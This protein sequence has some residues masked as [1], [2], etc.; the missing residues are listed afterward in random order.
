MPD[1]PTMNNPVT[2]D[3][4]GGDPVRVLIVDDRPE[5][6]VALEA[7][8]DDLNV[9]LVKARSG[10]EALG[11]AV[12][13][14]FA[15]ILLDVE[16]PGIDGFETAKLIRQRGRSKHT[17]ILFVTASMTTESDVARG[18]RIGAVD[19]VLKPFVPEVVRSKVI[20]FVD[21]FKL[22]RD[23]ERLNR[24]LEQKVAARTLELQNAVDALRS[25]VE[26]RK[27]IQHAL[28]ESEERY[29]QLAENVDHVFWI[30]SID[31]AQTVY[32]SPAYE[33]VWGRSC[34]SLYADPA[35]WLEAVE[36]EDKA[37]TLAALAAMPVGQAFRAEYRIRRPDG[38]VRW[39]RDNGF[40]VRDAGGVIRR[41]VGIAEDI[42]A[43]KLVEEA[44]HNAQAQLVQAQKMEAVG[45][46]AGGVAHD[47]NNLL[48]G[49][50]GFSQLL[51]RRDFDERARSDLTKIRD[52][53]ER[54]A[55]L[56]RQLLAFSRKQ[57]LI[58]AVLNVND[59]VSNLV[60][61]LGRLL[62]E[63]VAVEL[64]LAS[65]LGNICADPGHVEQVIMNLVVNA[66]DAM[67]AG[68]KV[69]IETQNAVCNGAMDNARLQ[70][71]PGPYVMLAVADTGS[72]M[73]PATLEHIFEPFFTTKEQGKGTGLG[74]A[75][76]YG[77]VQQHSGG[78]AV[79]SAPG[80]G[81]TFRIYLPQVQG[82]T[83]QRNSEHSSG[84]G[85]MGTE[86]ILLVEDE[87][88]VTEIAE[89]V[90]RSH[91]Y[92]VL[93]AKDPDDAERVLA[94]FSG[95]IDL[96]LTDIVMPGRNGRELYQALVA[97]RPGLKV[98]FMSGHT[99][100]HEVRRSVLAQSVAF[101]EK[102]FSVI[103][104]LTKVRE[105]LDQPQGEREPLTPK[106]Q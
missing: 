94:G 2:S 35:S 31:G 71:E 77:I 8:L 70:V 22:R 53:A 12:A 23:V 87:Q 25:E 54:A 100:D 64:R 85:P 43:H 56:T 86:T 45:R 15:A 21:L 14:E 1:N 82:E 46:L 55:N 26:Q 4:A 10:G 93:P 27:Q 79:D 59:L 3:P 81:T 97:R 73:D 47:F 36:P 39:I 92:T 40:P 98:L 62:G 104:L 60:K 95:A 91:G 65:D 42:T 5:N 11:H 68:G 48:T 58:P 84:E 66:R 88:A 37:A 76:V 9:E 50:L 89:R 67:P 83:A 32:V 49:I 74:L 38:A 29:R 52:L 7:V 34:A 16:M 99:D 78:I 24:S 96:L 80:K 51:L 20:N 72:G 17:P 30:T 13:D 105:V 75:T 103:G 61:M 102:P 18:Y 106:S 41:K 63:D 44:A 33:R 57:T 6:L 19:Y 90:L 101:L 28:Q 69:T